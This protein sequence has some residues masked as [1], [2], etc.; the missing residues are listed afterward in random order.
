MTSTRPTSSTT[1]GSADPGSSGG[2]PAQQRTGRTSTPA[3]VRRAGAVEDVPSAGS[4]TAL[5]AVHDL[6][7]TYRRGRRSTRA[8]DGIGF[9]VRPGEAVA[10]VGESGS[11]KSSIARAL[12]GILGR[13][14]EVSGRIEL[15]GTE[16]LGL[17]ASRARSVRGRDVAYVPQDPGSS[18]DPV[19][20][21][22]DQVIEPLR[23]HR[24][25]DPATHRA[26]AV[27]A[28]DQAG[29]PGEEISRRWPHE[30]S[31]GQRQRVLIAA[32]IIGE[33]RLIIA[34]EPTSA[35][36][37]TVQKTILDRLQLLTREHGTSLLLITHD[38]AVAADRT[39]RTIALRRGRI[40]DEGPSRVLLTAP[41]HPYT[42]ALV[43]AIP[44]RHGAPV[45]APG[46][47]VEDDGAAPIIDIRGAVKEFG[48]RGARVRALAG[49]DLQ[50]RPGRS[51]GVAGESG[52]GKTTLA[53][54]LLGFTEAD[55]GT[56]EVA[57][58]PVR[59]A[60]RSLRRR[61][62]PVFQN[63][64]S[65]FDP[66]RTV[67][68]SLLEPVRALTR[69]SRAERRALRDRLLT[70]VGLDP[71]LAARRPDELSGG[72]LQRVAI[73]RALSVA[74]EVLVCDEAVSALDVTVQA[75]ILRLLARLQ[76]D[77]GLTLV[78][79]THD[80]GVLRSLC[81][82]VLVMKDGEVVERGRTADVFARPEHPYT[83]ALLAAIPGQGGAADGG[84]DDELLAPVR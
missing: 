66:A 4:G 23:I 57:G 3:S 31:G 82:D 55:A 77:R 80:L 13:R 20:R 60:D 28:L 27:A 84:A 72:Q 79:I 35:L 6:A 32:A 40:V 71:Q 17:T 29:L 45:A 47:P 76:R 11:G 61:A 24:I 65:S 33:P 53:R 51:I 63:P 21:V 43:D 36:D 67:G 19:R 39:D 44:G 30:L 74:P 34:D 2:I 42:R 54:V 50:V 37:V 69:T 25:G 73:A 78:F 46:G 52:S 81:E 58:R 5:L 41:T 70:D 59:R 10:L 12:L 16:L 49:V 48:P 18:L 14:G 64:H 26:R 38:L 83:R 56:I 8:V 15:D 9:S 75:Q 68:W 22:I 62:Q 1:T 7:V